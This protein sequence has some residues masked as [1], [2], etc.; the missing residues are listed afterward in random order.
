MAMTQPG[1][2]LS[3]PGMRDVGVVPLGAHDGLDGIGDQVARLEREAHAVGAHGDAVADADGVEAHAD[4]SG[5][6]DA[7]LH[8]RGKVEQVHVAGVAFEPDAGDADL[9]FIMSASVMPVA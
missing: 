4:Q 3:Q 2:F 8:F 6:G 1:M 7:F 5:G 9:G